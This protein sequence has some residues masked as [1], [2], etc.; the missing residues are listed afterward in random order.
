MNFGGAPYNNDDAMIISLLLLY[1]P[2]QDTVPNT[3]D[4]QGSAKPDFFFMAGF[5]ILVTTYPEVIGSQLAI[6]W[7]QW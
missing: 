3:P 4:L 7:A 6:V 2:R 1:N 5:Y